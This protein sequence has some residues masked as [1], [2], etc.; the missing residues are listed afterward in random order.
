MEGGESVLGDCWLGEDVF[1]VSILFS[2]LE[3]FWRL[4]VYLELEV[5]GFWYEF[6][7]FYEIFKEFNK[8]FMEKVWESYL[9][10]FWVSIF[11]LTEK[12]M[13]VSFDST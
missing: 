6:E 4:F 11:I 2:F 9:I 8:S 12:Y 5:V 3:C 7:S 13:N 10:R 1:W